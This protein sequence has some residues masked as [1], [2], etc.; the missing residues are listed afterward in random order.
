MAAYARAAGRGD[1]SAGDLDDWR[2]PAFDRPWQ[3]D[4]RG[5]GGS[6]RPGEAM[7]VDPRVWGVDLAVSLANLDLQRSPQAGLATVSAEENVARTILRLLDTPLGDLPAHP[8]WGN[9]A[10]DIL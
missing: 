2:C 5:R 1:G 3:P 9:G 8:T 10:W 4:Q 6:A 7:S